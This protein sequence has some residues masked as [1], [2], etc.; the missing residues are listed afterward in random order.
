MKIIQIEELYQTDKIGL[1]L[2]DINELDETRTYIEKFMN[3][4]TKIGVI[5]IHLNFWV[6]DLACMHAC[7]IL[8]GL[9]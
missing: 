1:S 7:I 4:F 6:V 2:N 8:D 5:T 9:V 3:G